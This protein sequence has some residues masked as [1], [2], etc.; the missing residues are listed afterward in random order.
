MFAS[1]LA[2][3]DKKIRHKSKQILT[4]KIK[5]RKANGP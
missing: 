3:G 2:D 1:F 4:K 5:K